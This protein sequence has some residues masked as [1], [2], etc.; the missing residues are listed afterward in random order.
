M[1]TNNLTAIS[2]ER[3]ADSINWLLDVGWH[4]ATL[5]EGKAMDIARVDRT[6]WG[7]WMNGKTKIPAA[8]LE[9][10]RLH[11]FGETMDGFSKAWAGYRFSK[12]RLITPDRRELRP[13]DLMAVFMWKQMALSN[14]TEEGRAAIYDKLRLIY[15]ES[16]QHAV[17]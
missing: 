9:L 17:A 11:A 4:Y 10:L 16:Y 2:S 7:R 12:D 1:S 3:T 6:T 5:T 15:G 13:G 8:T 14:T